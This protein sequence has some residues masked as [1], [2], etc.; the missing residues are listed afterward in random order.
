MADD[1]TAEELAAEHSKTEL[2]AAA[3]VE[4]V[5]VKSKD[6]KADIAGKLVN[7][8]APPTATSARPGNQGTYVVGNQQKRSD[9]DAVLGSFVDVVDGEHQGR[10]GHFFDVADSEQGG[11]PK[12]VLVRTRDEFNEVLRVLYKHLRPSRRAGGR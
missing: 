9:D 4:G 6:T 10:F 3:A 1:R 11:F 5:D 8:D 12:T 7:S 2:A